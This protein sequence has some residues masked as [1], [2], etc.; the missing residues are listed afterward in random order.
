VER[1][2]DAYKRIH[3]LETQATKMIRRID[4]IQKDHNFPKEQQLMNQRLHHLRENG[5]REVT[6]GDEVES[7]VHYLTQEIGRVEDLYRPVVRHLVLIDKFLRRQERERQG[8]EQETLAVEQQV[9]DG[10]NSS[11]HI[12]VQVQ[13]GEEHAEDGNDDERQMDDGDEV[14][15]GENSADG[16]DDEHQMDDGDE[17]RDGENSALRGLEDQAE[18]DLGKSLIY[19]FR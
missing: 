16:K 17:V 8:S 12:E 18:I 5:E 15:D 9:Q 11:S 2:K 6:P 13:D 3:V 7:Q 1:L 14:H 19:L 10:N 4:E